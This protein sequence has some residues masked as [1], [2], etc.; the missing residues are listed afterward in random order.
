MPFILATVIS[1]KKKPGLPRPSIQSYMFPLFRSTSILL[2]SGLV[3]MADLCSK[4]DL[5]QE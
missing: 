2:Q 1:L 3:T 4:T 5:E